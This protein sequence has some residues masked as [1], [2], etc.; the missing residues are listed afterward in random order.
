[1]RRESG[2]SGIV[3]ICSPNVGLTQRL[4]GADRTHNGCKSTQMLRSDREALTEYL[5]L[6]KPDFGK[7]WRV[8]AKAEKCHQSGFQGGSTGSNPVG[9]TSISPSHKPYRHATP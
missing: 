5:S 4:Q 7:R 2:C 8:E 3:R 6:P 1:M 9:D